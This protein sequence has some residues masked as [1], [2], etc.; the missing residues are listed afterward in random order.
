MAVSQKLT[1]GKLAV[2]VLL[3]LLSSGAWAGSDIQFLQQKAIYWQ[4][5]GRSDLAANTWDQLLLVD[6]N[7]PDALAALAM[8]ADQSGQKQ[9]AIDYLDRLKSVAPQSPDIARIA[10]AMSVS[11][12]RG[13]LLQQAATLLARNAYAAAVSAYDQALQGKPVP[14]DLA[15]GYFNALANVPGG[16]PRAIFML[17]ELL[18]TQHQDPQYALVLGQLLTYAPDSRTKGI[19]LLAHLAEEGHGAMRESARQSWRQALV[20]E[21]A[22]PAAIPLLR[23]YLQRYPDAIL[24]AQLKK[25]EAAATAVRMGAVQRAISA[26]QASL[27][28]RERAGYAAL[29]VGRLKESEQIFTKLLRAHPQNWHYLEALADIHLAA[30]QFPDAINAYQQ[31]EAIAPA[32]QRPAIAKKIQLA[33]RYATLHLASNAA[34]SGEYDMAIHY[35][36][37]VLNGSPNNIVALEGLA[38]A[39]VA[40]QKYPEAIALYRKGVISEP[41]KA[42]LWISLIGVLH[43]AGQDDAALE[44]ARSIP[45]V[46]RS[47]AEKEAGYWAVIGGA[48]AGLKDYVQARAAFQKATRIGV[49]ASPALRLQLAWVLYNSGAYDALQHILDQIKGQPLTPDQQ[50]QLK[51]LT[52]LSAKQKANAAVKSNDYRRA[53]A[54]LQ[55]LSAKYP[56]DPVIQRAITNIRLL[57]AWQL[58]RDKDDQQLYALLMRLRITAN[59][60]ASQQQQLQEIFRYGADREAGAFISG[61]HYRAAAAIYHNMIQLFPEMPH[62]TRQLANV[63]LAAGQSRDA[64]RLF[65]HVGPGNTPGSY[66]EAVSAAFAA[67]AL[68]QAWQWAQKGLSF[69][70]DNPA[71]L[72]LAAQL[73]DARGNPV[74]ALAYYQELLHQMPSGTRRPAAISPAITVAEPMPPFAGD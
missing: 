46:V 1:H 28:I 66:A 64:Y 74:S 49:G 56:G 29:H 7:N 38:G 23:A 71:L 6:P 35:Y 39:Y 70:P 61:K 41:H 55:T 30:H 36:R 72:E 22:A 65:R 16:R 50:E 10:A 67:H 21:G 34:H 68:D 59:L 60:T 19:D 51:K 53:R 63:Y 40:Q 33:R 31:E 15:A 47:A 14:P 3:S 45:T 57:E 9:K 18:K 8:I 42:S 2:L 54:I 13:R 17:Q 5:H 37:R 69:W 20:W 73:A 11:P 58:Y 32:D 4:N 27:L 48:Y 24:A 25:A 43:S 26:Q 12:Q 52:V 62:Y 44:A